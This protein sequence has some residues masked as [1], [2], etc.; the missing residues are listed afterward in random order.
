MDADGKTS[1]KFM[2]QT[3]IHKIIIKDIVD[4]QNTQV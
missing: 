1:M 3:L 2:D 4:T